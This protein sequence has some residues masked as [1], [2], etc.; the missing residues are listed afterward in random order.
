MAFKRS[1]LYIG[2][3]V[4]GFCCFFFLLLFHC[5]FCHVT[6]RVGIWGGGK[7]LFGTS[8]FLG[9]WSD[10]LWG[11]YQSLTNEL[12]KLGQSS[13]FCHLRGGSE[14]HFSLSK[15]SW[16]WRGKENHCRYCS[17]G[18]EWVTARPPSWKNLSSSLKRSA[19]YFCEAKKTDGSVLSQCILF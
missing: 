16:R 11:Y 4:W 15:C 5:V 8:G 14:G 6:V 10:V 17:A 1:C 19:V 7:W 18:L 13:Y 12:I 2:S 9:S 3:K